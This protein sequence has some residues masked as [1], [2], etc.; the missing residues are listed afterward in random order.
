MY[1]DCLD[2]RDYYVDDYLH[3]KNA[4]KLFSH[5]SYKG[6]AMYTLGIIERTWLRDCVDY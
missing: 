3:Q 2:H 6:D 1:T 4:V 5:Y